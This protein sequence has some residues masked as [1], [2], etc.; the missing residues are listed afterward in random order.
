VAAGVLVAG[1]RFDRGSSGRSVPDLISNPL[2]APAREK[3][4]QIVQIDAIPAPNA[5]AGRP[6]G[7][8]ELRMQGTGRVA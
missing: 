2:N 1:L 6:M 5:G 8:H 7:P 3:V 4:N